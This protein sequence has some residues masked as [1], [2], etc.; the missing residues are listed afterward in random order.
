MDW[1]STASTESTGVGHDGVDGGYSAV[2]DGQL[3]ETPPHPHPTT[4]VV[5]TLECIECGRP[6]DEE[7]ERWRLKVLDDPIET[8]PYCPDCATREF[9]AA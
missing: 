6:W 7:T 3:V 1:F 9:G 4:V 5:S 2:P 8:V